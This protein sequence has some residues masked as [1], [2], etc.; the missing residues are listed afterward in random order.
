VKRKYRAIL[1]H[2]LRPA[3]G[4][5]AVLIG[6]TQVTATPM[7]WAANV[8]YTLRLPPPSGDSDVTI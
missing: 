8:S 3:D 5:P 7:M 6:D 1:S 4:S 2:V